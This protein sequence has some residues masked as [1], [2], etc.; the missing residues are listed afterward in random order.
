MANAAWKR[1]EQ[2]P[3][4]QRKKRFV[5]R[6]IGKELRLKKDIDIQV[7]LDGGWWFT[8]QHLNAGSIV[9]SLGVGDD[10]A[11]D[12]SVI[13]KYGANVHAFDPTP[14]TISM[15]NERTPVKGFHFHPW[16]VT[17]RDGRLMFYP[18]VKKDG[19][20]SKVMFTMLAQ[21][22]TEND[23]IEVPAYCLGTIARKL[24]HE[25][26]DLLKMDI[27]GAEYEVLEGLLDCSIRPVQLLIEFHHRLP[28]IGLGKTADMV[29]RLREIGYQVFAISE[30]GREISFLRL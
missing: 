15:I 23:G 25:R 7:M 22:E 5:K 1:F 6:L 4:W 19:S 28:G 9:Y 27:E 14:S 3:G 8:P 18:R 24:G 26:I 20:K 17:A 30:T 11:F 2:T 13:E 10:T 29:R 12:E 21:A 16:A